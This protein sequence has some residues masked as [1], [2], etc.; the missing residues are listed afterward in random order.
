MLKATQGKIIQILFILMFFR[1]L[2]I[3]PIQNS[4]FIITYASLVFTAADSLPS[5]TVALAAIRDLQT[6]QNL[7][8]GTL[9]VTKSV[10]LIRSVQKVSLI[11]C[12][13]YIL[14]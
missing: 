12:T 1:H 11:L 13:E 3:S 10:L 9:P 5:S 6:Q 4:P 7:R 8:L 2:H 14:L